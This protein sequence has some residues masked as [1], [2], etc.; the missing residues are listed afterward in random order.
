MWDEWASESGPAGGK[1]AAGSFDGLLDAEREALSREGRFGKI[2]LIKALRQASPVGLKE[3]K[4]IVEDYLARRAGESIDRPPGW[5]DGLIDAERARANA[6]D[7]P[8]NKIALIKAVREASGLGLKES[9]DI[10]DEYLSRR[11]GQDSRQ[12][13][14]KQLAIL[15]LIAMAVAVVAYYLTR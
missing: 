3:A 7:R 2:E 9:K 13:S 14:T 5:L 4:D 12:G 15:G 11:G 6:E 1:F 10:V 8:I